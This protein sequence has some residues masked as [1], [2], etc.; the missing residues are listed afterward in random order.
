MKLDLDTATTQL[1]V[2]AA[3]L[4]GTSPE[5]LA[6]QALQE[7][8]AEIVQTE[9]RFRMARMKVDRELGRAPR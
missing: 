5:K 3:R 8:L 2:R 1:L 6:P 9:D 4:R 7:R